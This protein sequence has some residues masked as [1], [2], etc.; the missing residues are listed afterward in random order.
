MSLLLQQILVGV[1][2]VVAAIFSAWRLASVATRLQVLE[3]LAAVP[4]VRALPWLAR[5]RQRTLARQLSACGGCSQ[6]PKHG[7]GDPSAF[8]RDAASPNQTPGALRR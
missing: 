3:R 2:V 5:L 8:R 1:I 7:P 6:A 4:G